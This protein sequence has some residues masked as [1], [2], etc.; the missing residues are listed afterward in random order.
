M[1]R[2]DENT[3]T[4][5]HLIEQAEKKPTM[6]YEEMVCHHLGEIA[7]LLADIS[8]SLAIIADKG[9]TT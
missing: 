5:N 2:T 8:R 3:I 6:P 7:T 1:S 4:I 9:A